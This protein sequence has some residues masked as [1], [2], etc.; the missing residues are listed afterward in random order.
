MQHLP[1]TFECGTPDHPEVTM[2]RRKL[3][4]VR[5]N[6]RFGDPQHALRR[7]GLAHRFYCSLDEERRRHLLESVGTD[8]VRY[9][10]H[11]RRVPLLR[12]FDDHVDRWTSVDQYL[13]SHEVSDGV[14]MVGYFFGRHLNQ[15]WDEA[16]E[17]LGRHADTPTVDEVRQMADVLCDEHSPEWVGLF[18]AAAVEV[19]LRAKS[20]LLE[21]NESPHRACPFV[22]SEP[23]SV[24]DVVVLDKEV[25]SETRERRRDRRRVE[26][27]KRKDLR[28]QREAARAEAREHETR[29]R[30]SAAVTAQDSDRR[31]DDVPD[32]PIEIRRL[33]HPRL[34]A[35]ASNT[36]ND[37]VGRIGC[38]FVRWGPQPEQGK[39]R[40]VVVI[41]SNHRYVWVRPIFTNDFKAGL[42]RSVVIHD[43]K[44]AGLDHASYV[45]IDILRIRR[46][47][48]VMGNGLLTVRDWNRVCRGEVHD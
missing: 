18:L 30:N 28:E 26:R 13:L 27:A 5:P 3:R 33:L 24:Q 6:R 41:G 21:F 4:N 16:V 11:V 32:V 31:E 44:A 38:A 15:I 36:D 43:W 10:G 22:I 46:D 14:L 25:D 7:G 2:A 39:A 35:A 45:S 40:P 47:R 9:V 20:Q 34:P 1:H 37:P 17:I 29:A 48:C 12:D 8:Y 23:T 42:W 19:K